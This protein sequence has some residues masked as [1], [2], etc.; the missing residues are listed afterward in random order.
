MNIFELPTV[1]NDAKMF[2]RV[3]PEIFASRVTLSMVRYLLDIFSIGPTHVNLFSHLR[4]MTCKAKS[5][6]RI[7][8]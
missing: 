2:N 1:D 8:R 7:S 6:K 4:K 3:V 5:F